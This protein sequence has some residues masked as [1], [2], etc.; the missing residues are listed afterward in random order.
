MT[1]LSG[2]VGMSGDGGNDGERVGLEDDA[3]WPFATFLERAIEDVNVV[4]AG[5][6]KAVEG[7]NEPCTKP[8]LPR[9]GSCFIRA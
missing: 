9:V 3:S 1:I 6:E 8:V 5:D 7:G 2:P 4:L